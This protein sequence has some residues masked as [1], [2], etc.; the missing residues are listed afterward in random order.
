MRY[1][2]IS[3]DNLDRVATSAIKKSKKKREKS[4][5]SRD[6]SADDS[7]SD[8]GAPF[9]PGVVRRYVL[10]VGALMMRFKYPTSTFSDLTTYVELTSRLHFYFGGDENEVNDAMIYALSEKEREFIKTS[11]LTITAGCF[12]FFMK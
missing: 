12:C 8:K 11:I 7:S 1:E 10:R 2:E 9:N 6:N 3:Q 4:T 5:S